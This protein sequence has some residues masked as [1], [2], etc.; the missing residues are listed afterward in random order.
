MKSSVFPAIVSAI[1]ICSLE[2]HG[3][4]YVQ[5]QLW[6]WGCLN[7]KASVVAS[8]SE[9][10]TWKPLDTVWIWWRFQEFVHQNPEYPQIPKNP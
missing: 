7:E 3:P 5:E 2:K 9:L 1:F 10:H 6:E 4:R 8:D